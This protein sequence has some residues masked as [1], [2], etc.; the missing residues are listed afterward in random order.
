VKQAEK[1]FRLIIENYPS[2]QWAGYARKR[3]RDP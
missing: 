2:T 3:I 1:T